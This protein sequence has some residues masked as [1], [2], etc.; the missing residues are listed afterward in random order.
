M[1]NQELIK[2]FQNIRRLTQ[3]SINTYNTVFKMYS[4]YNE[5]TLY[6][7]LEEAEQEE[8][9]GVRWKHRK[10]KKRLIEFR[11]YL[12]DNYLKNSAR[13]LFSK[14]LTLYRTYEIEIHD[15]PSIS[16]KNI[17]TPSPITF[18]ELPTIEII[19]EA[20]D[21]ANPLMKAVILFMSSSGT[22]RRE[23][24][25]LTIHDFIDATKD[26]HNTEDIVEVLDFLHKRDDII[27]LF[28]IRRQKTGKYYY[29]CCSPEA[30]SEITNYLL[31]REKLD[32]ESPLFK[33]SYYYMTVKFQEINDT[34]NLGKVGVYNK[35]RS[36]ML[37]KFHASQLYN[38]GVSLEIVDALQGRGKDSTHTSYFMEDPQKLKE[39]YINNMDCVTINLDVNSLDIK[40]PEYINLENKLESKENEIKEIKDYYDS[41]IRDI[42][43]RVDN[44]ERDKRSVSKED[45]LKYSQRL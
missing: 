1:K 41:S 26:Y 18:R 14:I 27:P 36:H 43:N 40:S 24:L 19:R 4:E 34:L 33:N 11:G 10:L 35:F 22:A 39:V 37:R 17:N 45:L 15:L 31:T 2:E 42:L 16:E 13:T 29:T 23:T 7:L 32:N 44:L 12:Y 8:E 28:Y 25:N 38:N 21:I 30:T 9:Q 3:S 5:K 6:E 20:I